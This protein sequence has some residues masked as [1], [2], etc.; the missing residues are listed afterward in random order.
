MM[1]W[2]MF[3]LSVENCDYLEGGIFS[4]YATGTSKQALQQITLEESI[5]AQLFVV[6]IKIIML[7]NLIS[8]ELTLLTS[9]NKMLSISY[10]W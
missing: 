5:Y 6:E 8:F 3:I 4:H 10:H 2:K 9:S 7:L 1:Q